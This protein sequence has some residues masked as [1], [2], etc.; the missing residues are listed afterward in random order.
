MSAPTQQ[1]T[2]RVFQDYFTTN[3]EKFRLLLQIARK[4][5]SKSFQSQMSKTWGRGTSGTVVS[6]ENSPEFLEKLAEILKTLLLASPA[7]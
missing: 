7:Q 3:P 5:T 1:Q 4:K 6:S 2:R